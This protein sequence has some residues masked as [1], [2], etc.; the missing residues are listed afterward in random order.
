[1]HQ[2]QGQ[3]RTGIASDRALPQ[4]SE[5]WHFRNPFPGNAKIA[6]VHRSKTSEIA[7]SLPNKIEARTKRVPVN[8]FALAALLVGSAALISASFPFLKIV[9]VILGG[10]GLVAGILGAN[11]SQGTWKLGSIAGLL[12]SLVAVGLGTFAMFRSGD[13]RSLETRL[14]QIPLRNPRAS[15]GSPENASGETEWVDAGTNAAQQD[16]VRVRVTSVVVGPVDFKEPPATAGKSKGAS[17]KAAPKK[18][19]KYLIIKLRISNAGAGRLI[20]YVGWIHPSTNPEAGHVSLRDA[21][22]KE[23]PLKVF[24]PE[25]EVVGQVSKSSIPPTKWVDDVLVFEAPSGRVEFLRLELPGESVGNK[26]NFH[27]QIPGRMIV[28]RQP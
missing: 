24:P 22:G 17:L 28:T 14:T 18:R 15:A 10:I 25:K 7:V 3:G 12:A 1:M 19:E 21:G 8:L 9:T 27:L 5:K 20:E 26:S 2:L 4:F 23:Y 16:E 6:G 11:S 13:D